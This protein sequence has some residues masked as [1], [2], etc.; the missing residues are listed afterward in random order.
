VPKQKEAVVY[1]I[2]QHHQLPLLLFIP[3][4]QL[5]QHMIATNKFSD[6]FLAICPTTLQLLREIYLAN[7]ISS[8]SSDRPLAEIIGEAVLENS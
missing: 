6:D 7:V 5:L 2:L 4:W 8:E 1:N 3:L